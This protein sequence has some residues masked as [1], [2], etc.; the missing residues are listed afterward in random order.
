MPYCSFQF[1]QCGG[2]GFVNIYRTRTT[3]QRAMM[4]PSKNL[5]ALG[6]SHPIYKLSPTSRHGD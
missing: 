6:T 5:F 4:L 3:I 1:L 2:A